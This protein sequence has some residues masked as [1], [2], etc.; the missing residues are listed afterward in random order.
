MA[1]EEVAEQRNAT[2]AALQ[3]LAEGFGDDEVLRLIDARTRI[4]VDNMAAELAAMHEFLAG[5]NAVRAKFGV[6]KIELGEGG[7]G[8]EEEDQ[9]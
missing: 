6:P 7:E 4:E 5:L 3:E 9:E 1:I 2:L 8:D